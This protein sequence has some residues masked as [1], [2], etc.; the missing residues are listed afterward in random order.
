[1]ATLSELILRI[2]QRTDNEH[3]GSSFVSESELTGLINKSRN[4]LFGMLV[5]SGLDSVPESETTISANGSR[6]YDLPDDYFQV[7]A[8]FRVEGDLYQRLERHNSRHYPGLNMSHATSYR[9]YGYKTDAKIEFSPIPGAG[10]YLVRYI[11][12]PTDL[13]ADDDVVDGVLGWEEYIVADVAIDVLI[14]EGAPPHIIS[15]LKTQKAEMIARIQTEAA[16]RD[17]AENFSV[18]DVRYRESVYELPGGY[19]VR[20]YRGPLR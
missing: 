14:K 18:Q 4:A 7:V 19:G 6:N 3:A 9:V 15:N 8:V 13:A 11:A 5:L 2:K 17:A 12:A 10:D 20:G 16:N 1:M